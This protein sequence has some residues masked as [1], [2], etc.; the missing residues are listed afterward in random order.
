[1]INYGGKKTGMICSNQW[2]MKDSRV[3]CGELGF[4][5]AVKAKNLANVDEYRKQ[6]Q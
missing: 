1:M 2:D 6:Y 3:A 4:T 5:H